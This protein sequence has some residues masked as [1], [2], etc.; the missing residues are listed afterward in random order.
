M[1]ERIIVNK[2]GNTIIAG[3]IGLRKYCGKTVRQ[4]KRLYK[5]ECKEALKYRF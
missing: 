5:G 3:K 4:A 2:Y 1:I